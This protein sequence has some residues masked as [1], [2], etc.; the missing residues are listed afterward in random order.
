[1]TK[2]QKAQIAVLLAMLRAATTEAQVIQCVKDLVFV[3][4]MS[5][6]QDGTG[7]ANQI[8]AVNAIINE[9]EIG[10]EAVRVAVVAFSEYAQVVVP[11]NDA[12]AASKAKLIT[13]MNSFKSQYSGGGTFLSL[14]EN[15]GL[16]Q[17]QN[18]RAGV[19]AI[20]VA[21]TDFVNNQFDEVP[22]LRFS[23]AVSA[24]SDI[25]E[26]CLAVA[27]KDGV[28]LALMN[29][30]CTSDVLK[31]VFPSTI[32]LRQA[33][34]TVAGKLCDVPVGTNSPA[35]KNPTSNSP[36]SNSPTSK[37]PTRAPTRPQTSMPT[38]NGT[39][40]MPVTGSPTFITPNETLNGTQPFCHDENWLVCIPWYIFVPLLLYVA[41]RI[42]RNPAVAAAKDSAPG[43]RGVFEP[44]RV[45]ER[46]K[47]VQKANG[48]QAVDWEAYNQHDGLRKFVPS[49]D[50]EKGENRLDWSRT[51]A[52]AKPATV[53][54]TL[55]KQ[56]WLC[57]HCV[58]AAVTAAFAVRGDKKEVQ[59]CIDKAWYS[60]CQKHTMPNNLPQGAVT[61]V[62]SDGRPAP[63]RVRKQ[64]EKIN[65]ATAAKALEKEAVKPPVLFNDADLAKAAA[66]INNKKKGA[67][68]KGKI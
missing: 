15:A 16:T 1:M 14:G 53:D 64:V 46:T 31:E 19:D 48:A 65:A 41:A 9:L 5:G 4:D 6:S 50:L 39:F 22:T 7:F 45:K 20:V 57:T 27:G 58:C 66:G 13:A 25:K 40:L 26:F 54:V 28:N 59:E 51:T 29:R 18:K 10:P 61:A 43:E 24:Y 11:L 38:G 32:A 49:V 17:L 12:A 47:G 2:Y 62:K 33:A 52:A 34:R 44:G 56:Q 3:L 42:L 21:M 30:K 37:T 63:K 8:D 67:A 55:G 60:C 68:S 35:S 23:E 36:T